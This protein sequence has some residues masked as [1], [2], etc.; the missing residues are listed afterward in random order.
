M[1][2]FWTGVGVLFTVAVALLISSGDHFLDN[3]ITFTD[4]ETECRREDPAASRVSLM[5]DN[6]MRFSGHFPA[7][8]VDSDLDYRYSQT[9][10]RIS[11]NIIVDEPQGDST[12]FGDVC[13]ASVVYDARTEPLKPGDYLVSLKH[14][15]VEV[16]RQVIRV[17]N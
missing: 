4:L 6:S 1:D 15:G 7:E 3:R 5:P 13:L 8:D 17:K 9:S 14:D 10:N 16:S 11:L 2:K 12:T